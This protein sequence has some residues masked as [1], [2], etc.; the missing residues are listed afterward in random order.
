V[1]SDK[2]S[3]LDDD[4]EEDDDLIQTIS[5]KMKIAEMRTVAKKFGISLVKG[6]YK[7][8]KDKFKTKNE[9]YNELVSKIASN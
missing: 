2:D 3:D 6:K 8:G 4:D 1:K 5:Q 9:L 7:N